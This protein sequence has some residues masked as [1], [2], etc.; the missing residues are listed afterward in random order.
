MA[1]NK[2]KE[3]KVFQKILKDRDVG[4]PLAILYATLIVTKV[5]NDEYTLNISTAGSAELLDLPP[6]FKEVLAQEIQKHIARQ[7]SRH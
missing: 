4:N 7:L 6:E 5:N 3:S 1:A 2:L